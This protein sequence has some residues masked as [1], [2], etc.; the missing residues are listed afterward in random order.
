M[1]AV[2]KGLHGCHGLQAPNPNSTNT[3]PDC[4]AEKKALDQA[5]AVSQRNSERHAALF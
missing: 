2:A 4:A 1:C 3:E 5:N